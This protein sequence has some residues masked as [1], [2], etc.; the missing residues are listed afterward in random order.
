MEPQSL[1]ELVVTWPGRLGVFPKQGLRRSVVMSVSSEADPEGGQGSAWVAGVA[2]QRGGEVDRPRPAQHPDDQVAQ[3]RHDV[4]T[5]AG[6]ELGGVLGEGSVA[7]VVQRLDGPVP[8]EQVSQPGGA[9][10]L[11]WEAGD[12]IDGYRPPPPGV[13]VR[14]LRVLRVTCRTWAA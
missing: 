7:D 8:A 3:G 13:L 10:L 11:K 5:G 1:V 6:A 2:A 4:G 9:S 14:R 12:G